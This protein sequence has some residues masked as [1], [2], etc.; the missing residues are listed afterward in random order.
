[1]RKPI[2][3]IILLSIFFTRLEAQEARYWVNGSG[4]WHDT[5][6]WST[7][8]G[9]EAGAS[10]PTAENAVF[11]D[12]N[13]VIGNQI[14]VSIKQEVYTNHLNINT[15]KLVLKGKAPVNISGSVAV[16]PNA[17]LSKFRGDI[18][19]TSDSKADIDFATTLN[20]TV[21]FKGLGTFSFVSDLI[22][23][24]DII[25]ENGN[26]QTNDFSVES[27]SFI[28]KGNDTRGL[29]LGSSEIRVKEWNFSESKN[30]SFDAGQSTIFVPKDVQ[31]SVNTG[32][33]L[34][35]S[36]QPAATSASKALIPTITVTDASCSFNS[37]GTTD[38]GEIKVEI[39]GGGGSYDIRLFNGELIEIGSASDVSS[40]TFTTANLSGGNK[41]TS[42][43][44]TVGYREGTD[45][46]STQGV[47]V[48]P[49]D[50]RVEIQVFSNVTCPNGDDL[51]LI[52]VPTGGSG[53]YSNYS[54][55]S[56][57]YSYSF[58][59]STTPTDLIYGDNYIV[60]VTDNNGC[61]TDT[62][63]YYLQL[64]NPLNNYLVSDGRPA[65]FVVS[66]V[67]STPS[68]EDANDGSITI[69]SVSGGTPDGGPYQYAAITGAGN[70]APGD[71]GALN[72]IS[73]LAPST[74]NVWVKDG[75]NCEFK[76]GTAVTVGE[77][78]KPTISTLL[79]D[80]IC[81]GSNYT[82]S[83]VV[84]TNSSS[85]TWTSADGKGSFVNGTTANP[86][87]IPDI[88]HITAG[89]IDL[90]VTV[91]GNGTCSSVQETMTLTINSS[92][93]VDLSTNATAICENS[94]LL[95]NG[96]P[97]GGSTVYIS[98][99][100]TGT[101]AAFLTLGSNTATPTFNS[102]TFGS[103][104]LTYTVTDD[105]NC[106]ANDNMTIT[107]EDGPSVNAGVNANICQDESYTV[108]VGHA[109]ATNATV[110]WTENGTGSITAGANTLTPTYTPGVGETGVVTLTITA[111][112]TGTCN[113]T[114]VVDDMK[115]TIN[116]LPLPGITGESNTCLNSTETYSTESGMTGYLWNVVDGTINSGQGTNN[117]SVTW[118]GSGAPSVSITYSNANGCEPAIPAILNVTV[119]S[120]PQPDLSVNTDQACQNT[121]LFL[122]G[123]PIGGSGIY[124]N[125]SWTGAGAT[126]LDN[127][128]IENP[129]FNSATTGSFLLTYIV[130]DNNGCEG[131]DNLTVVVNPGPVANAGAAVET[132]M[133]VPF[134]LATG[135]ATSANGTILWTENGT[136]SITAG[137]TTL[138][139]TYTPGAGETGDVTLTLTV[140]GA[141]ACLGSQDIDVLTL[142]INPLP[143]PAI[144]GDFNL[145]LNAT[146]TYSTEAG[147]SA[148]NWNVVGG[149][150]VSG[151]G[152]NTID[153]LWTT[154]GTQSLSV[155]YTNSNS[156]SATVPTSQNVT[157]HNA[158]APDL[159][160]NTTL[161]CENSDL[162]LDGNPSGGSNVF[163]D[164][165]WTGTGAVYL[166]GT[167]T[168]NVTF[169]SDTPGT[170][171][172]TYTV[173]DNNGCVG[174]DN[175]TLTVTDGPSVYAGADAT[176]CYDAMD[177]SVTD[178]TAAN[179]SAINWINLT[180][181]DGTGFD[182]PSALNPTYTISP[183]DRA[184]GFVTLRMTASS[185]T[186]ADVSDEMV[187]NLSPEL[188]ASVGGISPYLINTATTKISVSF[189]LTHADISQLGFYLVA[190]DGITE[191]ELYKFNVITDGCNPLLAAIPNTIDSLVFSLNGGATGTFNL[192]AFDGSPIIT[193]EF[194]PKDSWNLINGLDPAEGGWSIRI[195][196]AFGGSSGVLTRA[197]IL[198]IDEN[199]QGDIQQI[200]F[201]SKVVNDPIQ[202]NSST[203]F[204]VPMGLRTNCNGAC[205][206]RAIVSVIGGTP[207]YVS[208]EWSTGDSGFEV[209]LCGGDHTVTVTDANGCTSVAM[210]EV[211]EPDPIV[212]AV[213]S[214]NIA[215]F[216]GTSGMV[217]VTPSNGVPPYNYLWDDANASA[218]AQVN[219]L[220]AGTYTV[221]VTDQNM[222]STIRSITLTEP[223]TAVGL[224]YVVVPT[225]CN[226][227]TGTITLTPNG[228]TPYTVGDAYT[229]TWAH[230]GLLSGNIA[231]GLGVGSYNVLIQDSLGCI[232]DTTITMMDNGDMEIT[233]FTM[234]SNVSCAGSCDAEVQVDFTGGTGDYT[235]NWSGAGLSG[236][237]IS[238]PNV[239][240]DSTYYVT[241][242][243]VNTS[244]STSDFFKIPQPDSLKVNIVSQTDVLCFGDSTGTAEAIGIGG[245]GAYA[246]AWFT[247]TNDTLSRASTANNL[248]YGKIYIEI[249]DAN[250]CSVIDSIFIN[251]PTELTATTASTNTSCGVATGTVSITPA[252]G[253]APYTYLWDDASNATTALVEDLPS[254]IYNVTVT[255]FNGCELHESVTVIDDSDMIITIDN[256]VDV[257]CAGD[258]SGEISISVTDAVEPVDYNW[259][260]NATTEDITDLV[261][262]TYRVTVTDANLCSR[263]AEV[264]I[265]EPAFL[266]ASVTIVN[267]PLCF[268][269][270]NGEAMVVPQ[271]GVAPYTYLWS[272]GQT[273]ATAS[274]LM[275][276]AYEVILTDFNGCE[277]IATVT[278]VDPD[279]VT[280]DF[281]FT[282]TTCGDSVGTMNVAN[283]AGGTGAGTYT[284]SW[285]SPDWALY[286]APDSINTESISYLWVAS[287]VAIVTDGNGCELRDS[288]NLLDIS[289]MTIIVDS[290]AVV[291]CNGGTNG[292]I[293]VSANNGTEPYNYL[294][295]TGD[296][297]SLLNDVSAGT[298]RLVVTDDEL[299]R[300]DTA[301]VITEP[302][303]LDNTFV[304]TQPIICHGDTEA[305]FNA[306]ISGGVAPYTYLWENSAG[307]N[308]GQTA[309][310]ENVTA[311]MYYLTVVDAND[312]IYEDSIQISEPDTLT[313]SIS[314]TETQCADSTGIATAT[315][316]GGVA[317]YTYQWKQLS[318]PATI[319]TGQGTNT[320]SALWVDVFVLEVSD[321]LGCMVSDT[322]EMKDVSNIDFTLVVHNQVSC[323][324]KCD[325][326]AEVVL[327]T[328]GTQFPTGFGY[329][330][331]WS[332]GETTP[333]ADSLCLGDNMVRLFDANGCQAVKTVTITDEEALK[334]NI[335]YFNDI[336]QGG[337][338]CNGS[339]E[340]IVTGGVAPY[341]YLWSTPD[342]NTSDKIFDLCEGWYYVTVTDASA[343]PVCE[344]TDSVFI[345]DDPLR[346]DTLLLQHIS[347]Y[348]DSAG[349]I[350]VQGMGGYP[351]G[352]K[353]YWANENWSSYPAHDSTGNSLTNLVAGTY[354]LTI[355]NRSELD[356]LVASIVIT[357][358]EPFIPDY[359]ISPTNCSDSTGV[360]TVN[361][362]VIQGGTAPFTFEWA[363][364]SW[365][366]H[367][368]ADSTGFTLRN[369]WVDDYYVTITDAGGC[370]YL[371]TVSMEDNSP[372]VIDP[373]LSPI[374]CFDW[375]NG[376]IDVNPSN[377]IE[378]YNFVWES[379]QSTQEIIDLGAGLYAVTVTDDD[380]CV[381]AS[382][383]E[384]TQPDSIT[385]TLKDTLPLLCYTDC[386]GGITIDNI[387]GG[388]AGVWSYI[389][390]ESG[391]LISDGTN[392]TITDLCPGDYQI[393]IED[394]LGC[395]S[396][397]YPFVYLS[398]SPQMLPEFEIIDTARCNNNTSDG[399]MAVKVQM[400]YFDQVSP[401]LVTEAITYS[402]R[403]DG[404]PA[405]SNDTL[406][407]V[408]GGAHFVRI[409]D[410][411]QC[412]NTFNTIMPSETVIWIDDAYIVSSQLKEDYFCPGDTVQLFASVVEP[413]SIL[414]SNSDYIIGDSTGPMVKVLATT[415]KIFYVTAYNN[416]CYDVDTIIVGRYVID[417]LIAA[418]VGDSIVA[419]GSEVK[420]FANS[421]EVSYVKDEDFTTSHSYT[422]TSAFADATWLPAPPD[423]IAPKLIAGESGIITV[424]DTIKIFNPSYSNQVCIVSDTLNLKVLSSV[425]ASNGFTPNGDGNF[426]TWDISGING[427]AEV[428]VQ[429]FNRWGGLIWEHSGAYDGN[430]KWDGTNTKGNPVPSGTYYYVIT[431]G[432][433]QGVSKTL[434]GPVTILR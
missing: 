334:V 223:A 312:C 120:L 298:Y 54:W 369:L 6:H 299:C 194:D 364:E 429:I 428:D 60:A 262:G 432:N 276:G 92:P 75:N 165:L 101:G 13:S 160:I 50:F 423:T 319:L 206:A 281:E 289:N 403:W 361:L 354:F 290:M 2:L 378:P 126:H 430:N 260:N 282:R 69:A 286:P 243:D 372:F 159:S 251:Q 332:N 254:G 377:G 16:N 409:S 247:T 70:P 246:Y 17:D 269:A 306:E 279:A 183:A 362:A 208:Y 325:A 172:L 412:Q 21:I 4:S 128:T 201:D 115:L 86:T 238:L 43:T 76:Y 374:R 368:F 301:F 257:L 370:T 404:N 38:D 231:T 95:L 151:T 164:H 52:A 271:G 87:F 114:N 293:L 256:V 333:E 63:F 300:R 396:E 35:N 137:A 30:L 393:R 184:A 217:K 84:I 264:E 212:L 313:L 140:S 227:S 419:A 237:N 41:L 433:N 205:D 134:T 211:L 359:T 224:T 427:W 22:T 136:G 186:C 94:N 97:S 342:N 292:A 67:T 275:A 129:V 157:V 240:G 424:Y 152:T 173:T 233:G 62:N 401:E 417:P 190:P 259:S 426:D 327:P 1:M 405:L 124:T 338:D 386:D 167:S 379:G 414:W 307:D 71:Y 261:A 29:S 309:A 425:E 351:D 234:V 392:A 118:T 397:P 418:I 216:G 267:Q 250:L 232:L 82:F 105:N 347:C 198:F 106:S 249:I 302:D 139:P 328:G 207:P 107:V 57:I 170:Y 421:P 15:A 385:F 329:N 132:C 349:A 44:Y 191:V 373:I 116:P 36:I 314:I 324:D 143:S 80:A 317:P 9:G 297:D 365:G 273:T 210:V 265:T 356:T 189:S 176:L 352:Y 145:C 150:I 141:G 121:D 225:G 339:A 375:T 37:V 387:Q 285:A 149:T 163:T 177:Y 321:A 32:G 14:Q 192:C 311:D 410:N 196:D 326:R 161:T 229:Y 178:A 49:A 236:T 255:D 209:D 77:T 413:D 221:T 24:Q 103:Y 127:S 383:I 53:V 287:Y 91:S 366:S 104:G 406:K 331:I 18:A 415:N 200:V 335:A 408:S 343:A 20:S 295:D 263:V 79:D 407:Q 182:D 55:T 322:F 171:Q 98:H 420:L 350:T 272:D 280:F 28:A 96:N 416:N 394:E 185:L 241:V 148:Y 422:W 89:T 222:C 81:E 253:T 203:T 33:L 363:H 384:L 278:L 166:S 83:G 113:T 117:I 277:T 56:A 122:S 42:G 111:T 34:Y 123:N 108:P 27:N 174:F 130:T 112:G 135:H 199:Q 68:C 214:T 144:I 102:G 242:T 235:F 93:S 230:D 310:L 266:S 10:V 204:T 346:Y 252:G 283:L 47:V 46:F 382:S 353:Y 380:G 158:P 274:N 155:N 296:A 202:D 268:G 73:N 99:V 360:I 245:T 153:V 340:A 391:Q 320:L 180:T 344:V 131:S 3:L 138:T 398:R 330:V 348:G 411:L 90:T 168:Q 371:D 244:C 7:A 308:L 74:Y 341:T 23:R 337:D 72:T 100:W 133:D 175:M 219:G 239:C 400:G 147:M 213:D 26:V 109:S 316:T 31:K 119:N 181:G 291:N 5:S 228:G 431:Y 367:P 345:N 402:Y 193:G 248:P 12:D 59:G 65:N 48:G 78:P 389:I 357:Q 315:V 220:P 197:T 188:I 187:I 179:Y 305:S 40:Y 88:D 395:L 303:A 169:N 125:H 195:D 154:A 25:L 226:T 162:L 66:G 51:S 323:V 215:C 85:I 270:A 434:T 388:N 39:A 142:T 358:P 318:N 284:V 258:A 64:T 58:N 61:T 355:T 390:R 294:W 11:F 399:E 45:G 288:M 19:L 8:S 336:S 156:C 218:N 381:R 304:F 110:L 146:E 376:G